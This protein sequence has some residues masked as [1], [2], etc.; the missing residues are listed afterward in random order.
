MR[1]LL[2]ALTS[3][4]VLAS[5]ASPA[6]AGFYENGVRNRWENRDFTYN[7]TTNINIDGRSN[8]DFNTE[9]TERQFSFKI[10]VL[11]DEKAKLKI[12]YRNNND[13]NESD[14]GGKLKVK[15][16][17][18]G[19]PSVLFT[20]KDTQTVIAG[21]EWGYDNYSGNVVQTEN[22]SGNSGFLDNSGFINY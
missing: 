15:A 11:G 9:I 10:D 7:D 18:K 13:N 4:L 5:V 12:K 2:A 19:N 1:K 16:K 22:G 6:L 8:F 17:A 14:P 3:G 21:R 20:E